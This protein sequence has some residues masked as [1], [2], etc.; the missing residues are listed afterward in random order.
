MVNDLD[1]PFRK[2]FAPENLS[3]FSWDKTTSW[4]EERAPLTVACL[5]AM[6]PPTKKI[7]K[8]KLSFS[9][10]NNQRWVSELSLEG[11]LQVQVFQISPSVLIRAGW[12]WTRR[13]FLRSHANS[14]ARF[15]SGS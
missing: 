7:Q 12:F 13:L 1:G 8:Q 15:V 3:S 11:S 4:A 5:R 6:F 10:G 9:R 2:T 14:L